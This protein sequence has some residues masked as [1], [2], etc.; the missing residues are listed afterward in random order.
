ME[1]GGQECS[2]QEGGRGF[3]EVGESPSVMELN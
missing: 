1:E 3:L 2:E